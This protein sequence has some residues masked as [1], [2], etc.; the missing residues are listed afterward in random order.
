MPEIFE[1]Y[2]ETFDHFLRSLMDGDSRYNTLTKLYNKL[3][4]ESDKE[5]EQPIPY[6]TL[7]SWL[8]GDAVP[9]VDRAV[10]VVSVFS[11]R[12]ITNSDLIQMLAYS[13]KMK[14]E[15]LYATR[16]YLERGI[17]LRVKDIIGSGD[18][19]E[20]NQQMKMRC[21]VLYEEGIL[22]EKEFTSKNANNLNCYISW[23]IREDLKKGGNE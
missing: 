20:L 21:D 5:G 14:E 4:E 6:S 7:R 19:N 1:N 11:G 9:T 15:N 8:Q 3:V 12:P 2:H 22:N 23:L 10:R 16:Q 13:K 17:R 18:Y